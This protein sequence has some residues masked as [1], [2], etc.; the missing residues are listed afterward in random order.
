M[1][2]RIFQQL[3]NDVYQVTI[4]TEDWSELDKQLMVKYGEPEINL[5]G[6]FDGPYSMSFTLSDNF[7]RIMSESPFVGRFD[8]RDY[9]DAE[10]RALTWKTT[11]MERLTSAVTTLRDLADTFSKEE[12]ETI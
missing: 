10:D 3:E 8:S 9:A 2:A 7:V 6:E 4:V 1:K 11:V 5:G 12:V